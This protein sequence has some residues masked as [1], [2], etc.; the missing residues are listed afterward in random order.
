[1]DAATSRFVRQRALQRCEYCALPQLYH[2]LRFHV[3]HIRARQHHGDDDAGNLALAC[4]DCNLLK[5][6]N[7]SAVDPL[8]QEVVRIFDPRAQR[9]DEH[10]FWEGIRIEGS[11]PIGRAT[12]EL[13][14]LNTSDRLRVRELMHEVGYP[15]K[16]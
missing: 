7:L 3:E 1:M 2:G 10:F 12:V 4:P 8:T 14:Q 11:T 6:P 15:L 16:K 5:G 13:L 9:W